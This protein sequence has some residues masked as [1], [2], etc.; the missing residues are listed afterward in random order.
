MLIVAVEMAWVETVEVGVMTK[1]IYVTNLQEIRSIKIACPCGYSIELP[2]KCDDGNFNQCPNCKH[3]LP[4]N[5]VKDIARDLVALSHTM[6]KFSGV[7]IT[8]E[9]EVE[10]K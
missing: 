1:T 8:T 5:A 10:P 3:T 9:T 7:R 6:E 2:I 4:V